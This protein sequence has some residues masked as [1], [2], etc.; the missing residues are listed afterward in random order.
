MDGQISLLTVFAMYLSLSYFV[1]TEPES[2]YLWD[3]ES[4]RAL[5]VSQLGTDTAGIAVTSQQSDRSS[6]MRG[7]EA[8]V[9]PIVAM[10][11]RST[12]NRNAI[13]TQQQQQSHRD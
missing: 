11:L 3:Q 8:T 12:K 13:G 9:L 5:N 2:I 4:A 1:T 7:Y 6:I 10:K